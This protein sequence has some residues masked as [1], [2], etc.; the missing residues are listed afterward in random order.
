MFLFLIALLLRIFKKNMLTLK[1][2][3]VLFLYHISWKLNLYELELSLVTQS[4]AEEAQ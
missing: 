2:N 4:G 3:I 1:K